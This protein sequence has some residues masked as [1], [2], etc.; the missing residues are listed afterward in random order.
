MVKLSVR[1]S[2]RSRGGPL[3]HKK[4]F[5]LAVLSLGGIGAGDYSQGVPVVESLVRDLSAD[6]DLCVYLLNKPDSDYC[7]DGF[8]IRVPLLRHFQSLQLFFM[9]VWDHFRAPFNAV[10]CLWGFP[11]G[12]VGAVFRKWFKV[13]LIIHLQGADSVALPQLNYGVF[14]SPWAS[15]FVRWSYSKA[16]VLIALT[17]FQVTRLRKNQILRP[18]TVCPYGANLDIFMPRHLSLQTPYRFIHVANLNLIKNQSMLLEAFAL[19]CKEVPA[20]LTIVGHDALNG[21]IQQLCQNLGLQS[22][23]TFKGPLPHRSVALEM[24]ASHIM[25]LTSHYEAQA[26]VVN[27][28][29]ACGTVVCGSHVGLLADLSDT[30]CL[31]VSPSDSK[32]LAEKVLKLLADPVQYDTLVQLGLEWSQHNDRINMLTSFKRKYHD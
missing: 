25:L 11:L 29:L 3:N 9:L 19:I 13:K 31:T 12:I 2:H 1:V 32:A 23:V 8:R 18:V 4:Q 21:S 16:D 28:A 14:L 10:H 26:V 22:Q 27:E 20:T 5:R 7:P 6:Y 24:Q 15:R 17:H 30:C